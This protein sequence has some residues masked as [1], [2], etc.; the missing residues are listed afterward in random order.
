MCC[1]SENLR[2]SDPLIN[3]NAWHDWKVLHE[4]IRYSRAARIH[5]QALIDRAIHAHARLTS[6]TVNSPGKY[7]RLHATDTMAPW[8]LP[9]AKVGL[10]YKE[11]LH[12][13]NSHKRAMHLGGRLEALDETHRRDE[14]TS[15]DSV[16]A[17]LGAPPVPPSSPAQEHQL[18]WQKIQPVAGKQFLGDAYLPVGKGLTDARVDRLS[19][20]ALSMGEPKSAY[21]DPGVLSPPADKTEMGER[22]PTSVI[23]QG[24][25]DIEKE[26]PPLPARWEGK[27]KAVDHALHEYKVVG[28]PAWFSDS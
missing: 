3:L 5:Q 15:S 28:G 23:G 1:Y 24:P 21:L 4:E 12:S 2:K 25:Q 22:S 8:V 20:D 10:G 14:R 17:F 13:S 26:F 7:A 11:G 6:T 16:I 18:K 9:P 27:G 19:M